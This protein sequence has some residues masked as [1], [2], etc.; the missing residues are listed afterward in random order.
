[1]GNRQRP[2]VSGLVA[3]VALGAALTFGAGAAAPGGGDAGQGAGTDRGADRPR[4]ASPRLRGARAEGA[5]N[6]TSGPM[7]GSRGPGSAHL[8]RCAESVEG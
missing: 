6:R 7:C 8:D 4:G 5:P 2:I 1:M 3:L